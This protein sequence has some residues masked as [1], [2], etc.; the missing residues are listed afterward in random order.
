VLRS[1][2]AEQERPNGANKAS[3]S[4]NLLSVQTVVKALFKLS[5]CDSAQLG[6]E[7]VPEPLFDGGV[8]L[9]EDS[10]RHFPDAVRLVQD[11]TAAFIS[12]SL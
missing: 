6:V 10:S 1:A 11:Y 8:T 5:R 9:L 2:D 4:C 12:L 7:L 3:D